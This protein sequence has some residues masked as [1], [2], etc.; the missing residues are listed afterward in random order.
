MRNLEKYAFVNNLENL[1]LNERTDEKVRSE[2]YKI[3]Y[4][5]TTPEILEF[6]KTGRDQYVKVPNAYTPTFMKIVNSG[7]YIIEG[8]IK[9]MNNFTVYHESIANVISRAKSGLLF[10]TTPIVKVEAKSKE[11]TK[12]FQDKLDYILKENEMP[13]ISQMAGEWESYSGAIGFKPILDP[14]FSDVP[15]VQVYPKEDMIVNRKY[16]KIISIVFMDKVV[17]KQKIYI[18]L[19][20]YGR[21]YVKYRLLDQ[22]NSKE[23]PLSTTPETSEL[24][25]LY[26]YDMNGMNI[27]ILMAIYKENRPGG[28]SDYENIIDDFHAIDEVYSNSMNVVRKSAPRRPMLED[29]LK[30]DEEGKKIV[31]NSYDTDIMLLFN[32]SP[33]WHK[34]VPALQTNPDLE[35]STR[36]YLLLT[37]EI[38]RNIA[39]S[40]GLSLKTIMGNDPAGANASSDALSIRENIDLKTRDNMKIEWNIALQKLA[41][42]L[43][44]LDTQKVINSN[45]YVDPLEELEI[46]VEF[47]N[48]ATPTF[49]QI[50]LEVKGLLE[51][52][53]IDLKTALY[54]LWVETGIKSSEEVDAMYLILQGQFS[55]EKEM[56]DKAIEET[57]TDKE[58]PEPEV[59]VETDKEDEENV[60]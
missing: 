6:Y 42:L 37:E 57:E 31:P 17:N 46:L 32:N 11:K 28:R 4:K 44:I 15:I 22:V 2:E 26:F 30:Q 5:G 8:A 36:G 29:N 45:V 35:T 41:K 51:S 21:G 16:G 50:A 43:L 13:V 19:S 14:D 25:D 33:E 38:K 18:L 56:L 48:P 24:Q 23:V 27:D 20:E 60:E 7:E 10:S 47:Y 1:N 9:K 54:R 40:V 12:K 52:G 39:T 58:E 53:L 55:T 59:E 34:D 3:W 49:E